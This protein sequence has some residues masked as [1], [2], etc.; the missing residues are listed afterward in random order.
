MTRFGTSGICARYIDVELDGDTVRDVVFHGGCHGYSQ[1]VPLLVRG[2]KAK[3]V[4]AR[5]RGISCN[6]RGTSCADQLAQCLQVMSGARDKA[7]KTRRKTK[8]Q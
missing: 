3:D 7:G 1:A 6:G 8:G 2:M 5:L 4:I